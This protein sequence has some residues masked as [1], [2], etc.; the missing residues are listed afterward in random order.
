[1]YTIT[2]GVVPRRRRRQ[3]RIVLRHLAALPDDDLVEDDRFEVGV[4]RAAVPGEAVRPAATS[5]VRYGKDHAT[6]DRSVPRERRF[7]RTSR[8]WRMCRY[9]CL[10]CG[11]FLNF[12]SLQTT[13]F[14]E[15]NAKKRTTHLPQF[16]FNP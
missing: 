16:V 12:R 15:W 10:T 14:A 4:G 5:G 8:M 6:G 11:I 9:P 1:M 3:P 2:H 7:A 13:S